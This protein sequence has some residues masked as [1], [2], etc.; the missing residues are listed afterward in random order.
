M[1]DNNFTIGHEDEIVIGNLP[2][3]TSVS[4]TEMNEGIVQAYQKTWTNVKGDHGTSSDNNLTV[5]LTEDTEYTLTNYLPPV[6]P[7]GYHVTVAPYILLLACGLLLLTLSGKRRVG[8]KG[9]GADE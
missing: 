9:G 1:T 6:A 5:T 8:G 4:L 3:N 7:T 2:P